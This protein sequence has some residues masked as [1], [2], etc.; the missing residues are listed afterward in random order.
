MLPHEVFTYAPVRIPPALADLFLLFGGVLGYDVGQI[1]IQNVAAVSLPAVQLLELFNGRQQRFQHIV[2]G[3]A[4]HGPYE[5][6]LEF[7]CVFFCGGEHLAQEFDYHVQLIVDF[8]VVAH[9]VSGHF[10][11]DL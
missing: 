6:A 3:D 5:Y 7:L 11:A 10:K 4:G 1:V 8:G 9:D 2:D